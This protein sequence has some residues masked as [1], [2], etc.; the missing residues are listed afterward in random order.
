M[1]KIVNFEVHF[2]F[3]FA[4]GALNLCCYQIYEPTP[5]RAILRKP[6]SGR[7]YRAI[8]QFILAVLLLVGPPKK[9]APSGRG[10]L[11]A[12]NLNKKDTAARACFGIVCCAA[13]GPRCLH[14]TP[15]AL[16]KAVVFSRGSVTLRDVWICIPCLTLGFNN[17]RGRSVFILRITM[18]LL[19]RVS[20]HNS[21]AQSPDYS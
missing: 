12:P 1:N 9:T 10:A 5:Y 2:Q 3:F 17:G 14:F 11:R 8:L 6:Y 20:C 4:C 15:P 19:G 7:S 21:G 18:V 13:A 16:T